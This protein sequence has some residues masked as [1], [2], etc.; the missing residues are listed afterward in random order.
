[1]RFVFFYFFNRNSLQIFYNVWKLRTEE[2]S[3]SHFQFIMLPWLPCHQSASCRIIC[4]KQKSCDHC[5]HSTAV[6]SQD[7]YVYCLSHLKNTFTKM[8]C[9]K[10][11]YNNLEFR[12]DCSAMSNFLKGNVFVFKLI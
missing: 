7:C 5:T 3:I 10:N 12:A 2:L 1:M 8:K 6:S 4:C 9:D 11:E